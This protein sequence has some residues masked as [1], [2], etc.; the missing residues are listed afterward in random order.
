MGLGQK[1]KA[2]GT[3]L[4][5]KHLNRTRDKIVFTPVPALLA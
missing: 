5:S 3:H 2:E 4:E 1:I